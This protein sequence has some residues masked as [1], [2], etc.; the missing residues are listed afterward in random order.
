MRRSVT[1]ASDSGGPSSAVT[2]NRRHHRGA[3]PAPVASAAPATNSPPPS[4]HQR[5]P[6][7]PSGEC[8]RE[9]EV[10]WSPPTT[11]TRDI[12]ALLR[13]DRLIAPQRAKRCLWTSNQPG[14]LVP[15]VQRPILLANGDH[16][17][18]TSE[19]LFNPAQGDL[20]LRCRKRDGWRGRGTPAG[21][22]RPS[23]PTAAQ[24]LSGHG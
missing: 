9:A 15:P 11:E 3:D 7:I 6:L 23:Q 10:T 19:A 14:L 8:P 12:Y 1:W 4:T 21:V 16:V 2:P 20:S 5:V 17:A 24:S 18:G 13:D 22:P